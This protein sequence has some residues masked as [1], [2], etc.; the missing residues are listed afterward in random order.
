MSG[1]YIKGLAMTHFGE[2]W[3]KDLRG[4]AL[5]SA[6]Q[7]LKDSEL[8]PNQID[9]V[10]VANM[11]SGM[12]TG[13]EHL[14]PLISQGLGLSC[15][16]FRIE[17][18]CASGGLAI[19]NAF[20]LLKSGGF[21]NILVIG[22]EKMTDVNPNQVARVLSGAA[23]EEWE[24]FYG[25]TFPSLYA[26]MAREHMRKFN[27]KEED[28]ALVS[29]KNHFN[30][31]L[32]PLAQ[33]QKEISI[34]DVM[35]STPVA[36][37]LK[38]LD[39]S[40]ITD[41]AAAIILSTEKSSKYTVELIAS[42]STSSTLTVHDRKD[43]T[44]I[45]STVSAS[46][47]AY[48]QAEIKPKEINIAEVHDCFTIAEILAY[49]DLGFCKKGEGVNLIRDGLTTRDGAIPINTSGGLK[50]CGHPVGATGVKQAIEIVLQLSGKAKQRQLNKT[51]QYGLTQNVGGS[52]ATSVVS[53]YKNNA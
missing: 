2:L 41:G 31:K 6:W 24:S 10:I 19:N 38:L 33:F 35:R 30:G 3:S 40:P 23:D 50:A 53:I 9:C 21:K 16:S 44:T 1:I 7:A 28:L 13:Q 26:L 48:K 18:A 4:L 25:V 29:V 22:V 39:C 46:I 15:S 34:A 27:T 14:G 32:N 17:G 37:P 5:E 43:I 20:Y 11:A 8:E 42:H 12:L 49:E 47:K 45:D 36:S 52:G 51:L